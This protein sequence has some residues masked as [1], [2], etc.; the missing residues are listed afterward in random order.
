M[1][2]LLQGFRPVRHTCPCLLRI[3]IVNGQQLAAIQVILA[4]LV[5]TQNV[6]QYLMQEATQLHIEKDV[7]KLASPTEGYSSTIMVLDRAQFLH[8]LYPLRRIKALKNKK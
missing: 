6:R 1:N 7:P 5:S 8:N 2:N 4:A 3:P